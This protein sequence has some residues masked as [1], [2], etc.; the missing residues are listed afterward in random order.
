MGEEKEV[1]TQ[2]LPC[3]FLIRISLPPRRHQPVSLTRNIS[4]YIRRS[5]LPVNSNLWFS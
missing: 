1:L 3:D 4:S 5:A 2:M